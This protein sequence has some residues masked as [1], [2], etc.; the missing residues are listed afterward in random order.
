M[1]KNSYN[2]LI[3]LT[4]FIVAL[5]SIIS[6]FLFKKD[7]GY[8]N[9]VLNIYSPLKTANSTPVAP[10]NKTI[11]GVDYL[12]S[13]LP[14][15]KFHGQYISYVM[16]EVATFNPYN[17]SDATSSELSEIMY[18]G[19][20][21][22]NPLNGEVIPKLAKSYTIS[23]DKKT[24]IINLRRGVKWSDGKEIT[25]KDVYFTYHD[26]IFAGFGEGAAK[27]VMTID[28]QLPKVRIIDKYTVEFKT[29]KPF[30]P[31][32]RNLSASILP[33][34]IFKIPVSK[35]N[36]AFLTFQG[37]DCEAD[38]IV[39]S[40]AF[41]LKSYTLS[42]RIIFERNPNYYLINKEGKQLPY[43]DKWI[44]LIV[45][46]T[47]NATI[48]FESGALDSITIQPNL[49]NRYRELK[50]SQNFELYNLGPTTNTTFITFNLN[51][52]KNKQGKYYVNPVKQKWFQDKNFRSAIEKSIDRDDLTLNIFSGLAMPL[53]T[54]EAINSLY[55]NEKL[56]K[57]HKKD[58]EGAIKLLYKSGFYHKD[59]KL[60]DKNKNRVEFEL[61]TNAGNTQREASGVSI[62]QDIEQLGIK[63]NFKPVEFN[64]LVTKLI[65]SPDYDCIIIALTSNLLEPN[66]GYNVWAPYGSSHLFNKRTP[67]DMPNTDTLL[68]FEKEIWDLFNR[69]SL[70]FD[71][72]K[73][74]QIYDRYQQIIFDENPMIYLYAPVNIVAIKN[75]FKNLYPTKLNGLI[76]S[77][78]DIYIDK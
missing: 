67:Q 19:L 15:G 56:A 73:R 22:T 42:Q 38:K 52:R 26:V 54:A 78:S 53:Y 76:Y 16:G 1:K 13:N 65:N 11:N 20:V 28:G 61:L 50:K 71:F 2:I 32:L 70:E 31:F 69:G 63:V 30:A 14:A 17:S 74:K 72:K 68:G 43:L 27:D 47:N 58:I 34:H 37:I 6:L 41:H 64:S 48:K 46:D 55:I 21:Q 39:Y 60:Y 9:S 10:V 51:N 49:L 3:F 66:S 75:K 23:P 7:E 62:K 59:G 35:G 25:S 29:P 44:M 57:G 24:Y 77:M 45:A 33:E 5:I 8:D 18:D 36:R 4:I 40:G 12:Q